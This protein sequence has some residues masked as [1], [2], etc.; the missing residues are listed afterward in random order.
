MEDLAKKVSAMAEKAAK[1]AQNLQRE[2]VEESSKPVQLPIWAEPLRGVPNPILRSSLFS[3]AKITLD[4]NGS[5]PH[6]KLVE[7]ACVAGVSIKFSGFLLDQ[8]DLDVWEQCLHLARLHPLGKEIRFTGNA[9]LKGIGKKP[10][11]T[12]R[13]ALY[14]SFLRLQSAVVTITD[15][16]KTYSGQ[17]LHGWWRDESVGNGGEHVLKINEEIAQLYSSEGWSKIQ[18]EQR[19]ALRSQPLAQWLHSFYS[20]HEEPFAYK[21]ETIKSL[22]GSQAKALH[23]FTADVKKSMERV[24]KETGWQFKIHDKKL[25]VIKN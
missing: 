14:E 13:E 7:K 19:L 5:R 15:K 10:A 11:G 20:T 23:H 24:C 16:D 17:L 2:K 8:A 6:E 22:C 18:W 21:L 1:K 4:K 25:Y 3:V 12:N 9:F